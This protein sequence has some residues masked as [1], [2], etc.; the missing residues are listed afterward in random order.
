MRVKCCGKVF[1]PQFCFS[2]TV[3]SK[4]GTV[5]ISRHFCTQLQNRSFFSKVQFPNGDLTFF[6]SLPFYGLFK[7]FSFL[8]EMIFSAGKKAA[9]KGLF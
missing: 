2:A 9:V 6:I 4:R 3:N 7:D 8:M 5:D 1:F